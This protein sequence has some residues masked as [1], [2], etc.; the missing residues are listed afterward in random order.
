MYDG[1][2]C[3]GVHIFGDKRPA[4]ETVGKTS[5]VYQGLDPYPE[6]NMMYLEWMML[7]QCSLWTVSLGSCTIPV[8]LFV[9]TS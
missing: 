9:S 1:K 7:V 5:Y 8:N 4:R 2:V 3:L 6:N